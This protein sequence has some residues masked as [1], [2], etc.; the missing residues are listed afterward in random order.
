MAALDSSAWA[1]IQGLHPRRPADV[2]SPR[3]AREDGAVGRTMS[4]EGTKVHCCTLYLSL[5][6]RRSVMFRSG[7]EKEI[8]ETLG[9][10]PGFFAT[11]PDVTPERAWQD[12]KEF[13]LADTVLTDRDKHLIGHAVASAIH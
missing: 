12:L 8:K 7:I 10:T 13:Q 5:T 9:Q 4:A 3:Q 11:M 6:R 1:T 2:S